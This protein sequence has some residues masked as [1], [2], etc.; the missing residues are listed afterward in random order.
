MKIGIVGV[1]FVGTAVKLAYEKVGIELVCVDPIK[2]YTAT[3]IDLNECSAVFV[4]VPS[5]VNEDGSCNTSYLEDVMQNLHDYKNVI[6]SKVT[7]PADIYLKLQQDHPTLVHTPEFLRAAH[8]INDYQ[9][10]KFAII[11]GLPDWCKVA[12]EILRLAQ[13][14]EKSIHIPI[15]E[16]CIVKYLENSFLATKVIFMNEIY[17]LC[18]VLGFNY[19]LVKAAIQLD[20]RQGHSHFDVPGPDGDL[21][22][23]GHCFPKDTS[24]LLKYAK[25]YGVDLTVLRQA[26]NQNKIIRNC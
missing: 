24:A 15:G 9:N 8:A 18:E 11:G 17:N 14:I 25:D 7:A 1:G 6:I 26:V 12:D 10:Q 20:T 23:G 22:F 4:C 16:A 5:P 13:P 3:F 19:D 21:G 2:G